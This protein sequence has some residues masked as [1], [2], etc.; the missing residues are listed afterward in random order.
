ME[1]GRH[2]NRRCPMPHSL[3]NKLTKAL[4]WSG[5]RSRVKQT[6]VDEQV[7]LSLR[8]KVI[9]FFEN[10]KNTQVIERASSN[11]EL[12]QQGVRPLRASMWS[13]NGNLKNY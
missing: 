12:H 6:D 2:G 10:F 4:I 9:V 7:A 13:L 5:V 1:G 11:R 3:I 8:Q